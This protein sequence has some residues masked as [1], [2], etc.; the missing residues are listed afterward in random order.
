MNT[1][2]ELKQQLQQFGLSPNKLLSQNF[3]LDD[4]IV[5]RMLKHIDTTSLDTIIEV[6]PG[7][8]VLTEKL[9]QTGKKIIAVE[10]DRGIVNMLQMKFKSATNVTIVHDDILE[11]RIDM[12]MQDVESYSIIA[13]L[14][15]NITAR[16]LKRFLSNVTIKPKEIVVMIQKEVAERLT[17]PAGQLTK[18]GLLA[19][20]YSE[21]TIIINNIA[22]DNFYPKPAVHSA[23]VFFKVKAEPLSIFPQHEDMFWRLVRIGFSSKRKKLTNNL[24]A[25]LHIL[26]DEARTMLTLADIPDSIRAEGV[27]IEQWV[28]LVDIY[29]K[30]HCR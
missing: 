6:G 23:V 5:D 17:A 19:Q 24:A 26:P 14:P 30:N 13:N 4:T 18:I 12:L 25:G 15:Y 7:L 9:A 2:E 8:G 29:I 11:I 28:K 22:P 27:T 16:F 10:K 20:V 1:P 3:L 21:P